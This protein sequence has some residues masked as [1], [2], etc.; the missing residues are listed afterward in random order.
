MSVFDDGRPAGRPYVLH[1]IIDCEKGGHMGRPYRIVGITY[2]APARMPVGQ[3]LVTIF[4]F[5]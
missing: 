2:S 4:C 1:I 5:V 3:R